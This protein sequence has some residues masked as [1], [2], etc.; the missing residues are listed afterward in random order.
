MNKTPAPSRSSPSRTIHVSW[1]IIGVAVSLA[2][3]FVTGTIVTTATGSSGSSA[4]ESATR[5]DSQGRPAEAVGANPHFLSGSASSRVT[6]VEFTDYQCPWCARVFPVLQKLGSEY[7]N[8]VAIV[9]RHLPLDFHA[10]A[11]AAGHAI[12]AAHAQGALARMS[13][14]VY[15]RQEAWKALPPSDAAAAFASYATEVGLDPARFA[16]DFAAPATATAVSDDKAAATKLSIRGT[17]TI[18]VQGIATDARTY[19]DLKAVIDRALAR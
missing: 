7:G 4:S 17:P 5:T 9:P 19:P 3:G 18:L 8:D 15:E 12:E 1:A 2:I 14:I 11:V 16:A 10:N 13:T 6:V